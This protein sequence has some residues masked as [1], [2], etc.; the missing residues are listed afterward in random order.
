MRTFFLILLGV[1][2]SFTAQSQISK[3]LAKDTVIWNK[4]MGLTADLFQAKRS[5]G[6]AGYTSCG[7]LFYSNEK[8]GNMIF[9]VEALFVKSKSFLKDSSLYVLRHEQLHFDICE[10]YARKLRQ[11]IIARDFKKVKNIV[12]E[13]Q[14]FYDKTVAE[15]NR[16]QEKYDND[17]EHGMNAV[18]QKMWSEDITRQLE[19]LKQFESTEIDVV[20][21]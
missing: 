8:T 21:K 1:V 14:R 17:T 18:K 4:E 12:Q 11:K 7:I 13:I 15:L 20:N 5:K 6:A 3:K 16:E 10:L 19:E 2:T 9:N